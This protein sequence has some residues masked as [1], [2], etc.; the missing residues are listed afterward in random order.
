[1]DKEQ[2]ESIENLMYHMLTE[3][4]KELCDK[5]KVAILDKLMEL[6]LTK[7]KG[8]ECLTFFELEAIKRGIDELRV[9]EKE[10]QTRAIVEVIDNL[11]A[12]GDN[13][14]VESQKPLA[15]KQEGGRA[16]SQD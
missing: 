10:A 13:R 9:K 12:R 14:I 11:I 4:Y 7:P 16:F 2:K 8:Q 6:S 1:M 3:N 15:D 5:I